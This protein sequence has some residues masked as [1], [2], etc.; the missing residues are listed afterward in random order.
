MDDALL[1]R[2]TLIKSGAVAGATLL[3]ARPG[4]AFA[5]RPGVPSHL[6]RSSYTGLTGDAFTASGGGGSA[7]L[8]LDGVGDLP[9]AAAGAVDAFALAFSG[10]ASAPLHQGIRTLSHPALGSF[11]VFVAAVE[12]PDDRQRYEV[13]VDR[14]RG[15]PPSP[16]PS[17]P[18]ATPAGGAPTVTTHRPTTHHI[19]RRT[20]RH[21]TLRRA[22]SGLTARLEFEPGAG[23]KRLQAIVIHHGHTLA[24][25]RR[26]VSGAH[27][28]VHLRVAR[29]GSRAVAGAYDLL[30]ITTDHHGVATS[31]V[32][33]VTLH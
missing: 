32:T 12:R 11:D 29:G 18:G 6:E 7:S 25:T 26:T 4:W 2:R 30:T 9:D 17:A 20:V 21:A 33:R 22:G 28:A 5:G 13:V 3:I 31:Q 27:V 23:V 16:A 10:A 15:V 8:T 1:T 14:S 19:A 24:S